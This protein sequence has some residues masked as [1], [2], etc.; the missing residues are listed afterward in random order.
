MTLYEMYEADFPRCVRKRHDFR[1][2]STLAKVDLN[3]TVVLVDYA[4]GG[5]DDH[6]LPA[7][8]AYLRH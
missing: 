3:V 7:F 8:G 5:T 1:A 4:E 2:E 6:V